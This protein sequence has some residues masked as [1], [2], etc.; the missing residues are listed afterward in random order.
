M[1]AILRIAQRHGLWVLEDCA[2]AHLARFQGRAVGTMGTAAA[3]SFYPGKNL[4]AMG[5]AGAIVTG[6]GGLAERMAMFARHGGLS[7]ND[8]LMEG[9]NSRMDGLQAAV[10]S[11]KL[12]HLALWTA[13]RRELAAIYDREL[14][15]IPGVRIP[16]V[17]PGREHVYHL[18][19]IRHPARDALAARLREAG[20][21]TS[22]NYPVALPFLP[23]YARLHH[24]REDFPNAWADQSK[25]LAL[26]L[27]PEMT[28]EQQ[29]AVIDGIARSGL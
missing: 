1:E 29:R 26:P 20:I 10:L 14:A 13:K 25:I 21:A 3:F 28:P 19:V 27:Y 24:R 7:K 2:Q 8:H 12:K 15:R 6:N 18:Y 11:V 4:G 9:I 17:A 22:V 16:K 5:D 23:A